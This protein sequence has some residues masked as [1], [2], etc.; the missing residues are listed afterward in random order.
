MWWS[1][2]KVLWWRCLQPRYLKGFKQVLGELWRLS[3]RKEVKIK[4]KK[5]FVETRESAQVHYRGSLM[6][7]YESVQKPVIF[8]TGKQSRQGSGKIKMH[9]QIIHGR[10]TDGKGKNN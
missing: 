1:S 5:S 8:R 4:K 9:I 2:S 10:Q 3:K 7:E 6:W